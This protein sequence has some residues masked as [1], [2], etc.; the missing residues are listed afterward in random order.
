M[1][2]NAPVVHKKEQIHLS[3]PIKLI[4]EQ[5]RIGARFLMDTSPKMGI[6]IIVLGCQLFLHF[7]PLSAFVFQLKRR[8][9]FLFVSVF[10]YLSQ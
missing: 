5:F 4:Y 6:W 8:K 7:F 1:Y 3:T 10:S 2:S 9:K